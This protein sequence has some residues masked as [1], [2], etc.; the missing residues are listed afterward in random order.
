VPSSPSSPRVHVTP[1]R[2][3]PHLA[4]A[5]IAPAPRA[6]SAPISWL[7]ELGDLR[8]PA[9]PQPGRLTPPRLSTSM[10]VPTMPDLPVP[11][12]GGG[13]SFPGSLAVLVAAAAAA[14]LLARRLR[15]ATPAWQSLAFA[16][17]IERPG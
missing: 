12:S 8:V 5:P 16:S 17:L 3:D 11:S 14:S 4:P 9:L 2:L 1:P 7:P 15:F 10:P 13:H 6:V